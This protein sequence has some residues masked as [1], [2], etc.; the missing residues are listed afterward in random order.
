[1]SKILVQASAGFGKSSSIGPITREDFLKAGIPDTEILG[2]N[3]TETFII[4]CSNKNLPIPRWK[5]LYQKAEYA[6][7]I[8][9]G[10]G[11]LVVTNDAAQVANLINLVNVNKKKVVNILLDDTNYVMQDYYMSKALTTGYDVF[12]K[13]GAMMGSIFNE[14]EKVSASNKNFIMMAHSEEYKDSNLDTLSYRFKTVGKM[15]NDYITPEGKFEIVLFGKQSLVTIDGRS[16]VKKQFVT[17]YD[18]QY[19]AKSPIGMFDSL[20]IPNDLGYVL[21]AVK[22]Y[23]SSNDPQINA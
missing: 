10:K 14:M 18:G 4:S 2:L 23:E 19:P 12:K 16:V 11:N 15:V 6:D 22:A 20:Y 17:N 5:S 9:N 8:L 3:P 13:I 7:F 1:M 21:N